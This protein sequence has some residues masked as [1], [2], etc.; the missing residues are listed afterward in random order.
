[1][2][3]DSQH[4]PPIIQALLRPEAYPHPVDGVDIVETHISWVLLTGRFAYKIKKPVSFGFVQATSLE[5]RLLYCREE[6]RLNRRLA[7]DLYLGV[8]PILGPAAKA[9]IG[10]LE[11][12]QSEWPTEQVIDAAVQMR[13]FDS[14]QLLSA[15]LSRG[16]V[17]DSQI[18]TLAWV[19][20]EFHQQAPIAPSTTPLGTSDSVSEPVFTNL[21]V[22]DGLL[23]DPEQR[24]QLER[25]RRW[26]ETK[27]QELTN[28][29]TARQQS[30]AIR[31]CHGDLHCGNIRIDQRNQLEVFDAI[32]FNARL[33]WIDPI[34]EMAFLVMDLESKGEAIKANQLLNAWLECTGAYDGLD[35]WPWY[36]AYRSMVRAKVSALQ[37]D[38]SKDPDQRSR[39]EQELDRYLQS[40][41]AK[42]G[43]AS[44]AL[45]LMHGLSG[46]GKS[47]LSQEL[48]APLGAVRIRSDRER[49]RA[50]SSAN[51]HPPQWTG[52]RYRKE[53]SQWLFQ[54]QLPALVKRCL[55]SGYSVIVDAT[56]LRHQERKVMI[57][58]AEQ[59]QRPWAIVE[60]LCSQSTARAR[61][62]SRQQHGQDPS[63]ADWSVRLR[64]E[65]W[66]ECLDS[67]ER[68]RTVQAHESTSAQQVLNGLAQR[69]N[70]RVSA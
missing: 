8:V 7:P 46:S 6:L 61:L 26:A 41:A 11:G 55:Q 69:L 16:S 18:T 3:P 9:S 62:E 23:V 20:G 39:L 32:D 48:M 64:Q 49:A 19:L 44:G 35:L 28:R 15:A 25:H 17:S 34:S 63:E 22:L 21:S 29:F 24:H 43:S 50:F 31:E 56:F 66:L 37:L 2:A 65:Q 68:Q 42:E 33:R 5:E 40:A 52:D 59:L 38:T 30:G 60:C 36:H 4:H 58:L 53:I 54:E 57:Q 12:D 45:V 10:R 13:Q 27:Q 67:E 70:P 51:G 1:M 47:T 14:D